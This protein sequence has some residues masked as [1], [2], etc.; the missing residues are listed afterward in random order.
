MATAFKLVAQTPTPA[1][2]WFVKRLERLHN[3]LEADA[4]RWRPQT[5]ENVEYEGQLAA[6][7]EAAEALDI[8]LQ[9]LGWLP[10]FHGSLDGD[11]A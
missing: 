1:S 2:P 6:A 9:N 7:M 4:N 10:T 8:A 5:D 11:A 3:A